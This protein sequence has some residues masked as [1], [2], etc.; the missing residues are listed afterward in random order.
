MPALPGGRLLLRLHRG[1]LPVTTVT[2]QT[3]DVRTWLAATAPDSYVEHTA[4]CD[5][6]SC[7]DEC[8]GGCPVLPLSTCRCSE[9]DACPVCGA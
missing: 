3:S 7:G 9:P 8:V 6:V 4:A 5:H 1:R 2:P